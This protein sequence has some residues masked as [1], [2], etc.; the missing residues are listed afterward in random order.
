MRKNQGLERNSG[1]LT[2]NK[3][4][5]DYE[6]QNTKGNNKQKRQGL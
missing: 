1:E 3:T 2:M 6:N 4:D 5:K